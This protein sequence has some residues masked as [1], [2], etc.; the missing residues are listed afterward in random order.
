[1][2]IP[3]NFIDDLIYRADI[4]DIVSR[5][6]RL[7]LKGGSYWG[8]CPFHNE[9][10]PSFHAHP[11]RQIFKCFGCGEGG[12]ALHF[13]M[14]IENF[15]YVEA[16]H[17]LADLMGVTVPDDGSS[18]ASEEFRAR[19][20]RIL[21]L[22]TDAARYFHSTLCSPAGADAMAYLTDRG[23]S[24][25]TI[26]RFGIGYADQSWDGLC[27]A[28]LEKGYAES[29]LESAGL[30][31][32]GKSGGL[33][34]VF[35]QRIMFPFIDT[36]GAVVAFGGR[37][38]PG[39]DDERKYIN[40]PET[41]AYNKSRFLYGL[42]FAKKS[43]AGSFILCE[44][45]VDVVAL[46]QAGFDGAV[47]S[48]G[49]A[50]TPDQAKLLSRY[51]KEVIICYDADSAG[52]AATQKAI[53]V[54]GS[55]SI[56]VRVLTL[57]PPR[58]ES[59]RL[60]LDSEGNPKKTDP[61]EFIKRMGAPAFAELVAKPQTDGQYRLDEIGAKYDLTLQE[62]RISYLKETATYLSTLQSEVER[63]IFAHTAASAA[64]ISPDSMMTEIKR[65]MAQR[66]RNTG[67]KVQSDALK[68]IQNAQ[69][70]ER[71]LRYE[72]P[73][74]AIAEQ[75]LIALVCSDEALLNSSL[76]RLSADR[77]SAPL[78]ARLYSL[79][80]GHAQR[81]I[82]PSAAALFSS[83]DEAETRL[84]SGILASEP[85]SRDAAKEVN[86]CIDKINFEYEKR[87]GDP[88]DILR[89]AAERKRDGGA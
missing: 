89:L 82:A 45:N 26:R 9:K 29:E 37:V 28:M 65:Q 25:G 41:P 1:M 48:C 2:A 11:S 55:A 17:H 54:L 61:D 33:Y 52:R 10:S 74:S 24:M 13:I 34:C 56:K 5:Y 57:P 27:N 42:N 47:A 20:E 71:T 50:L 64:G 66:R 81:G 43:K 44:G 76:A 6:V 46:H 86:D 60:L 75:R 63:E 78:L 16:I 69:P 38:T 70:K 85:P 53:D 3:Q 67:K 83:L 18:A 23:M 84:L 7:N 31:R 77:F 49:T 39:S 62:Q 72:N 32:R 79:L 12:N 59:G 35:R 68:P 58:D 19:R 22:N 80:A 4:V 73:S 51:G 8:L 88:S 40:S 87:H 21:A 36:R 15:T 30:A 14:K